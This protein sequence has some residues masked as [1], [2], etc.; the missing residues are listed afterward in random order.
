MSTSFP[1]IACYK[2]GILHFTASPNEH[3][4][5]LNIYYIT[6]LLIIIIVQ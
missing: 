5:P 3:F 2:K 4:Y 6:D 1:L